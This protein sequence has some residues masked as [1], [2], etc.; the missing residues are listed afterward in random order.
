MRMLEYNEISIL[1]VTPKPGEGRFLSQQPVT[2]TCRVEAFLTRRS[3]SE[4][5]SEDGSQAKADQLSAINRLWSCSRK[6]S[7]E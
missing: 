1:P 7:T 6:H 2:P 5:G 3:F 4:G